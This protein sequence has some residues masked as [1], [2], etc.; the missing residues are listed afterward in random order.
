[1]TAPSPGHG[2][3]G[4][5]P[6][7]WWPEGERWPP[8]GPP[9]RLAPKRFR[10]RFLM[11][12]LVVLAVL[13][14]IGVVVGLVVGGGHQTRTQRRW[15]GPGPWA[16]VGFVTFIAVV[17]GAAT[18]VAYRRISRP[19]G[20]LLGA[21]E[22]LAQGRHDVRVEPGG[23]RELRSLTA[24]FND[25]AAR[26]AETEEQRRRFLAD[27]THELRTPLAVLQSGI[28]A[29]L[30][31]VHPRDDHHLA[32]LLEETHLLARLVDDLHTLALA[33]AGR[34]ALHRER[35]SPRAM[36]DDAVDSH[37]ALAARRELTL[38]AWAAGDAPELDI[39]P[40]RIRQ[41]LANLLSNA[42]RHT[43]AGGSVRVVAERAEAGVRFAVTDSGTGFPA[44]RLADIFDRS[45]R[46]ADSRG[47]GLGLAIARDLVHAHGGTI[48]AR[49]E[50]SGGAT[51]SFTVPVG[52]DPA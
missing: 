30:D 16:P 31:G 51:V 6:P 3:R 49:N 42:V 40:A 14:G 22:Q 18:L 36:V 28:E 38:E 7:P 20:D 5:R 17:G 12:A 35:V 41:V 27:V 15:G 4:R 25:M 52:P 10:R 23:P 11:A 13:V 21:A 32:S 43:P 34:L 33:D 2:P 44:D 37:A 19:V 1:M 50:A 48:E 45:K 24:T 47:S 46:P 8:R 29:Q 26:L 9:W 39:D